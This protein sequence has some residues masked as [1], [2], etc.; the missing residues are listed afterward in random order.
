MPSIASLLIAAGAGVPL[1]LGTAHLVATFVGRRLHPRE[2]GL[3]A[4]M[5]Q[6]TVVISRDMSMWSA[7]VSFNATHSYGAMLFG[8]VYAYLALVRPEVLFGSRFLLT[9]GIVA[10]LGYVIVGWRYWFSI[11]FRGVALAAM[12]YVGG[13]LSHLAG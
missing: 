7:W 9:L 12:L 4:A 13:L 5:K 8:L 1:V 11:P 10:L 6:S 3:I 2:P